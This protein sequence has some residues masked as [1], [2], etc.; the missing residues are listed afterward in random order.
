[1]ARKSTYT[2]EL[3]AEICER[4]STGEPLAVICRDDHMPGVQ[5]VS[6]W[7]RVHEDL[8]VNIARARDIGHDALAAQCLEISDNETH[9]WVMTKKG[10]LTNEVAVGRAKLQIWTRLQLLAKWNPKKYGDKQ[11]VE[12]TGADGGPVQISDTER[13]ARLAAITAIARSRQAAQ[14]DDTFAGLV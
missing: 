11:S 8:A 6:D 2:P 5:T 3:A 13:A 7:S 10:M 14:D 12:L 9:D 1:M 4:L